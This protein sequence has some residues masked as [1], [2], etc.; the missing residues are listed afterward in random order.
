MSLTAK[1][2][3]GAVDPSRFVGHH[4]PFRNQ[5]RRALPA[6]VNLRAPNAGLTVAILLLLGLLLHARQPVVRV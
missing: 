6:E 2:A 4:A 1:T 3:A 5:E